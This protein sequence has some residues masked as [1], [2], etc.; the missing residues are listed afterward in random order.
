MSIDI[1]PQSG[2][3]HIEDS[4]LVKIT[5]DTDQRAINVVDGT[6]TFE[7][8]RIVST[9]TGGSIL[10]LWPQLPTVTDGTTVTFAG[11]TP[12]SVFGKTL[13]LFTVAVT[14]TTNQ[15]I[16]ARITHAHAYLDD[17]T[18]SPVAIPDATIEIP[19]VLQQQNND[20]LAASIADDTIPPQP[21]TITLGREAA[22]YDGRYFISFYST[23]GESGIQTYEIIEGTEITRTTSST[24]VLKDQSL[25][26]NITVRAIDAAGNVRSETYTHSAQYTY[27]R[28]RLAYLILSIGALI[29]LLYILRNRK[30]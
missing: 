4:S 9:T 14:P 7:N 30:K 10:E 16:I 19:V 12:S 13:R 6:I 29:A 23:D 3:V 28:T 27:S 11:G 22:T 15:P 2:E 8:A 20:S 5:I 1:T 24:Y 21:F 17:G 25:S 26:K 18:G